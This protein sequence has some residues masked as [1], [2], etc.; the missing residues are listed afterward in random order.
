MNGIVIE[1]PVIVNWVR[2]GADDGEEKMRVE[3]LVDLVGDTPEVVQ[4]TLVARNGLDLAE[5]QRD[6]RWASPL[7][8]VTG[9][10]PQLIA[11]G[12]DPYE[13]E[14]PVTGF[15]AA[16]S[17]PTRERRALS[18]EF[19]ATIARE[20]L[21]RGRGYAASLAEDYFVSR[22]T[23]T[24]WVEKARTRGILSPAPKAGAVGGSLLSKHSTNAG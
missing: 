4:I 16:S 19:L 13:F 22:R 21:A 15:P 9:I 2:T 8:A 6:F 24:S 7:D 3:A 1:L 12:T 11:A 20:Y 14:L 17:Q 18:D 23:V 5:L 10:L